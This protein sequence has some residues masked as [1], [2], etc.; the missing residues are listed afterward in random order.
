MV[1]FQ[2]LFFELQSSHVLMFELEYFLSITMI[3]NLTPLVLLLWKM[4]RGISHQSKQLAL[5]GKIKHVKC[6]VMDIIFHIISYM[7]FQV[8][9]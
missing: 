4:G 8:I 5:I 7:I 6:K 3:P 9:S 2:C 1:T